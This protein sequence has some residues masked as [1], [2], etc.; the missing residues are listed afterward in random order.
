MR[1]LDCKPIFGHFQ[2][3]HW[4]ENLVI[5]RLHPKNADLQSEI[6][7]ESEMVLT[8]EIAC[9]ARRLKFRAQGKREKQ[10]ILPNSWPIEQ[11][12]PHVQIGRFPLPLT[13]FPSP[14]I[15]SRPDPASFSIAAFRPTVQTPACP[16]CLVTPGIAFVAVALS[17]RGCISHSLQCS[18]PQVYY[19]RMLPLASCAC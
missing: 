18:P 5:R 14:G 19:A 9:F 6:R 13:A 7:N 8:I 15:A 4:T 2:R 10:C 16:P 1:R 11:R 17:G 3:A 12:L